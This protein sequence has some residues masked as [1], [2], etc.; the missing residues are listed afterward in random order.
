MW[1]FFFGNKGPIFVRILLMIKRLIVIVFLLLKSQLALT[2]N[3]SL[4]KKLSFGKG[5]SVIYIGSGPFNRHLDLGI[6]HPDVKSYYKSPALI[7]GA[8][9]CFYPYASNAYLGIGP[10]ASACLTIRNSKNGNNYIQSRAYNIL[11]AAKLTHHPTYFVRKKFDLC[12]GYILGFY[13]NE[14]QMY[15]VN[16]VHSDSKPRTSFSPAIG[17]SLTGRYYFFKNTGLYGELGLGYN[18]KF[19]NIGLCYKFRDVY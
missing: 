19:L 4:F 14:Y 7:V 15:K 10:F 8:D 12:T 11:V 16:G 6:F 3:D 5:A 9:F 13:F 17:V 18:T 1:G 2:A